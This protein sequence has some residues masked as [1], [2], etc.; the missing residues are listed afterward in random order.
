V[1]NIRLKGWEGK[2][3]PLYLPGG[4]KERCIAFSNVETKRTSATVFKQSEGN[5]LKIKMETL[6]IDINT[7]I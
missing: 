7:L 5:G 2:I 1:K 6:N 4:E 3:V